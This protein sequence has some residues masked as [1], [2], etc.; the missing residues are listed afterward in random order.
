MR[1]SKLIVKMLLSPP[2]I[3]KN[4][5][6]IMALHAYGSGLPVNSCV[7]QP[8]LTAWCGCQS[9]VV[10][11]PADHLFQA[12]G[13]IGSYVQINFPSRPADSHSRSSGHYSHVSAI[14]GLFKYT[15]TYYRP[16]RGKSI[17]G[18]FR[19]CGEHRR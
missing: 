3:K 6:W 13:R 8:F 11:L 4:V 2:I 14:D 19:N 1:P 18:N 7:Q 15:K 17:R 9:S 16:S 12:K 10:P 5:R